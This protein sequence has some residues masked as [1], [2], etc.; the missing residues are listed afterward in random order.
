M[1]VRSLVSGACLGALGR[2]EA[3]AL[4]CASCDSHRR[5]PVLH[6]ATDFWVAVV[7]CRLPTVLSAT[8]RPPAG[9]AHPAG[10]PT[11]NPRRAA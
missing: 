8:H 6:R 7:P 11:L 2:S 10:L 3:V 1:R 9:F 5:N 4:L